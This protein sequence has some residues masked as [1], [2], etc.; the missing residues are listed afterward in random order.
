MLVICLGDCDL[1]CLVWFVGCWL[2]F[3]VDDLWEFGL[4]CF[5]WYTDYIR[6]LVG[7]V[8]CCGVFG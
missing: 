5:G 3:L 6:F 1:V 8:C 2:C 7:Q 4:L